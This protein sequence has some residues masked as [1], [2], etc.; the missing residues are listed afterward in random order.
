MRLKSTI[1]ESASSLLGTSRKTVQAA[2]K[3]AAGTKA[4]LQAARKAAKQGVIA[5]G[6]Q[7]V[8]TVIQSGTQA[9][10]GTVNGSVR[11]AANNKMENNE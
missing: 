8:N 7:R 5:S 11:S 6:Q 3:A 4:Q 1:S 2:Q 9:V 10:S